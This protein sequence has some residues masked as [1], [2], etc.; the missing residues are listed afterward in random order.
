[1]ANG[2][3]AHTLTKEQLLFLK[4]KTRLEM[5]SGQEQTEEVKREMDEIKSCL[6]GAVRNYA[7]Q[8][9]AHMMGSLR[10]PNDYYADIIQDMACI[11]FEQLPKYD[12]LRTTPTTF[13]V[14]YFKQ[15]I[16]QYIHTDSQHLT[17]Y[18][19]NNIRK[20]K[21]A[22]GWLEQRGIHDPS[23]E[24][25][26]T[27]TGLSPN[28]VRK[29]LH[30][31]KVS[32]QVPIDDEVFQLKSKFGTP[33]NE[34]MDRQI[35][36]QLM[37][38]ITTLLTEE[39]E[40]LFLTYMNLDGEK[41][42][43]FEALAHECSMPVHKAKREIN[44][45]LGKLNSGMKREKYGLSKKREETRPLKLLQ[46]VLDDEFKEFCTAFDEAKAAVS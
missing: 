37:H 13:F 17:Q 20:V 36:S 3:A 7:L 15:V 28:V 25:L 9:M 31:M 27:V 33:E 21:K 11:F 16:G 32:V 46:P 1:M 5:L 44:I 8:L 26:S 29:T 23:A 30:R 6:W 4:G 10:R 38:D 12:P 40:Q 34:C 2:T 22:L 41:H 43:T 18:D 24:L 45:I 42:L 14:R 35:S 19:A 39:E